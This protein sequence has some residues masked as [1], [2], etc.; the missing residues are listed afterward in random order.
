MFSDWHDRETHR[1]K[2]AWPTD[3]PPT[4]R[5]ANSSGHKDRPAG[6]V[7]LSS[8]RQLITILIGFN[9]LDNLVA[10][11]FYFTFISYPLSPFSFLFL[12]SFVC[13]FFLCSTRETIK[14]MEIRFNA[15]MERKNERLSP[16]GWEMG[17][18]GITKKLLKDSWV[19]LVC[20]RS[21]A[22]CQTQEKLGRM[23]GV[24]CYGDQTSICPL[25]LM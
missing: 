20:P 3:S 22:L 18:P 2:P 4:Q 21:T 19:H 1:L 5:A 16:V 7:T 12:F 13:T 9:A 15:W 23:A 8:A 6:T 10:Q 11:T 14:N 25:I 24:C 17:S